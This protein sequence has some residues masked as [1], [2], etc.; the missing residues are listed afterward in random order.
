QLRVDLSR[1]RERCVVAGRVPDPLFHLRGIAFPSPAC[2]R[3]WREATDEGASCIVGE[4]I[5]CK[6]PIPAR[7]KRPECVPDNA[8]SRYSRTTRTPLRFGVPLLTSV[9]TT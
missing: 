3:R 4:T 6:D 9:Q 8:A 2:G 5:P 7:F 1:K